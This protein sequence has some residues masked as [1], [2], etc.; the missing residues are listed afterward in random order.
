MKKRI[1]ALLLAV[2][3]VILAGCGREEEKAD[4]SNSNEES[5][6]GESV[7]GDESVTLAIHPGEI[8]IVDE[9]TEKTLKILVKRDSGLAA[10]P[11]ETWF[12]HWCEEILNINLEV[13]TF[14]GD[15]RD[16]K[17]ALAFAGGEVPD[18]I[19]GAGLKTDE[20]MR[21]Y[22]EG[23][24]IDLAPYVD[25]TH[26]PQ[27]GVLCENH[28][29]IVD[30][31]SD[32]NGNILSLGFIYDLDDLS[33]GL[34]GVMMLNYDWLEDCNL[35]V[36]TT[37][38]GFYDMLVAFKERDENCYPLGGSWASYNPSK[39]I[40]NAL[41]YLIGSDGM[42]S[43]AVRDSKVVLPVADREA[44]GEYLTFMHKCYEEGLIHPDFC[45]MDGDTTK[46][47]VSEGV[48]GALTDSLYGNIEDD[49]IMESWWGGYPLTSEYNDT[50]QWL[51]SGQITYG[52]AVITSACEEPE[53]AAAFLDL[54]FSQGGYNKCTYGPSVDDDMEAEDCGMKAMLKIFEGG[55]VEY[56]DKRDPDMDTEAYAT[57]YC[58]LIKGA[59]GTIMSQGDIYP[60]DKK[61]G[62][63]RPTVYA[64]EEYES[65]EARKDVLDIINE[66]WTHGCV[67]WAKNYGTYRTN[68]GLGVIYLSSDVL[69]E[70]VDTQVAIK[71]YA[72]QEIAKFIVG[73]R[74]LD[75]LEEYFDTLEELGADE[76]VSVYQEAYSKK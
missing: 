15:N 30:T 32:S 21:Y 76:Y 20:L 36:P 75:T 46:A 31:W 17:I 7:D 28:P 1:I 41:G 43:A 42:Y 58:Q 64:Y 23:L 70:L 38:D 50:Q 47:L 25:K 63:S 51:V 4:N 13:T 55:G 2:T 35:D 37:L 71:E 18:I 68:E 66:G 34:S 57:N 29:E 61:M 5:Q 14:N 73:N 54:P 53:L 74:S 22:E 9:G 6:N 33:A 48:F 8:P 60:I 16:E 45:T 44:F 52:G 56:L 24:I 67:A 40:L 72:S 27:L 69:G 26:M 3:L 65:D 11:E 62:V 10:T 49:V 59:V 39:Y 12:Y 19:I